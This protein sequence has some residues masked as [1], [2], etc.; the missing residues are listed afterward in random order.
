MTYNSSYGLNELGKCPFIAHYIT[1]NTH[2]IPL[3]D[4]VSE[5]NE[6][7]CGSLNREGMTLWKVQRW[8]WYCTLFIHTRVCQVLGTWLWMGLVF[9]P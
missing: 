1:D 7:M 2:S 5:L 9:S 6:Y 8:L 3:P 4:N